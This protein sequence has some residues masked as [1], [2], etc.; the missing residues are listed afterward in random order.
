MKKILLPAI[1]LSVSF[2]TLFTSQKAEA[3]S[4]EQLA[5]I[6]CVNVQGD[7]VIRLRKTLRDNRV[8]LRDI[9]DGIKCNGKSIYEFAKESNSKESQDFIESR[10]KNL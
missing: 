1:I 10:I 9:Y 5:K 2:G 3:N 8:R 4:G 6:I 7:D